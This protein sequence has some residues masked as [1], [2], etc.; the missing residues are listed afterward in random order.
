MSG[1]RHSPEAET[2][3]AL[4]RMFGVS[5]DW[6]LS[7]TGDPPKTTEL[8]PPRLPYLIADTEDDNSEELSK[9]STLLALAVQQEPNAN[10]LELLSL[11]LSIG[12]RTK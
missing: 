11:A 7:G 12:L 6:L 8:I 1:D 2:I 9:A 4:S 3:V 5:T 10:A